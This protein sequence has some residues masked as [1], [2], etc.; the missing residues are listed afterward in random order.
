MPD[1]SK[2]YDAILCPRD[3][4]KKTREA[5]KYLA[6]NAEFGPMLGAP[7]VYWHAIP[8]SPPLSL[9][10]A[11]PGQTLNHPKDHYLQGERYSWEP[12]GDPA[13]GVKLGTLIPEP[14]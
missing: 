4:P 11:E 12:Y 1:P 14:E 2:K 3:Y 9:G 7:R 10:T 5:D 6:R 8:G 13:N